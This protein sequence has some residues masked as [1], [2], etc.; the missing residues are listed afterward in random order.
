VLAVLLDSRANLDRGVE[1]NLDNE[2]SKDLCRTI[3]SG[4]K[5]KDIKGF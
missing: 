2:I 3:L 5:K 4:E 1:G